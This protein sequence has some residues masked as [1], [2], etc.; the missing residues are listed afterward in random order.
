[1]GLSIACLLSGGCGEVSG[2]RSTINSLDGTIS[3]LKRTMTGQD[4]GGR[5]HALLV[6]TFSKSPVKDATLLSNVLRTGGSLECGSSGDYVSFLRENDENFDM[7]AA[8]DENGKFI[9]RPAILNWISSKGW[10]F[11]QKFCI[12]LN[13]D[14]IEYYFVK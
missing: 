13:A 9:V 8:S 12:N 1:M 14:N 2:L 11:Q 10:K 6:V 7:A 4:D 5:R 3:D